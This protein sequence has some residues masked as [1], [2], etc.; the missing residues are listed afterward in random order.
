METVYLVVVLFL[1]VLAI[2]DLIVGVANDAVNFLNSAIGSRIAPLKVI[3]TVASLGVLLGATFS[4]GMMEVARSGVFHPDMFYFQ[5]VMVL[6]VA[7]MM[8]DVLLLDLFN[9]FGLPTSTTVSLV[10]DLLGA[11]VA[12]SLFKIQKAGGGI[13]ELSRY[14]NTDKALAIIGGILI[15]VV[16]AFIVGWFVQY[17]ARFLFTFNHERTYR[18]Y[19][20]LFG[21]LAITSIVYFMIMKGAKGAS[22]MKPEYLAYL[23]LHAKTLLIANVLFWTT[24][25]QVL[26][27]LK[28]N[29]FKIVILA[30]TFALAFAFAGNDLVNFIGVPM[31]G[32]ASFKTWV[33]G[34][35][36]ADSLLMGSLRDPVQSATVFLLLAGTVMSLT[37]WFSK[38][39]HRVIQTSLKLSAQSESEGKQQFESTA[40]S[41]AIVRATLHMG[42]AISPL[43]PDS[44]S[45][46]VSGR[47]VKR[48]APETVS[49]DTPVTFDQIRAS[50]NLVTASILI[51]SATSLKLPLSTTYV[52]FMVA[53]G[54]SL[55]DGAWDR[56]S[57]VYRISG[58]ITVIGGWFLTALTAFL[59]SFILALVISATGLWMM[60][61]L[62]VIVLFF[63]FRDVIF[64]KREVVETESET[65]KNG[66]ASVDPES[67]TNADLFQVCGESSLSVLLNAS[68]ISYLT[69]L[70]LIGEKRKKL[71]QL[72]DEAIRLNEYTKEQRAA[73][74]SSILKQSAVSVESSRNYVLV[75]DA[76]KEISNCILFS[77]RPVFDHVDNN[78]SP[79][80]E[81]QAADLSQFNE[82]LASFFNEAVHIV[83]NQRYGQ[84]PD[85]SIQ[86]DTL[87]E[88]LEKMQKR[89]L[90]LIKQR[91]VST[92]TSMLYLNL[93]AE[94]K[95]MILLII[96]MIK[97]LQSFSQLSGARTVVPASAKQLF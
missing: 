14:I 3:L 21:G 2:S 67:I 47:F 7:V 96:G 44:L 55:A 76:M 33:A 69:V 30:G 60:A 82:E 25:L 61:L 10:F 40:L 80:I 64:G 42:Q 95:T 11:A 51:A 72:K 49:D 85:L 32:L 87:L 8:A 63:L 23:E 50:V 22:F 53:M 36:A 65:L 94:Y 19:G 17:I 59:F 29:I 13:G 70:G 38:K 34:D 41:R 18:L 48:R 97:T 62:G 45:D 88:N 66:I 86:R 20:A 89:Q 81:P 78:H 73:V 16:V 92:R 9:T 68:K 84:V 54:T 24:L 5:D 90:K 58:V 75:L 79:L 1:A 39:A 56:E 15:S 12:V 93:L 28:V 74:Y 6:F 71:K 27:W 35:E 77:I 37:L 4:S 52:T 26:M 31:A 83:K 43:I 57:A 91:D 46:Y